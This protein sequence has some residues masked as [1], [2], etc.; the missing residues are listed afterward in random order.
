MR[1]FFL[2]LLL[3]T[4]VIL[5]LPIYGDIVN[6][7]EG[8]KV[9]GEIIQ[10]D[11]N[12]VTLNNFYGTF[13]IKR[14]D[15]LSIIRTPITVS[16]GEMSVT[17]CYTM[18]K[19]RMFLREAAEENINPLPVRSSNKTGAQNWTAGQISFAG[20]YFYLFGNIGESLPY[21]YSG[22]VALDQELGMFIEKRHPLIPATRIEGGYLNFQKGDYR[23]SGYLASVGAIW[24]FSLKR[25]LGG[26]LVFALLPGEAFLD[27]E[28]KESGVVVAS[29][30][31]I[32]QALGGYQR[33]FGSNFSLFVHM[34]YV[35]IYDTDVFFNTLGGSIG[36]SYNAW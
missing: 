1:S 35:Y 19:G 33:S 22:H 25:V 11:T 32:A 15:I 17:M 16:Y 24:N 13:K 31:F 21:G 26:S 5:P 34:R 36:I 12:I 23:I 10:E 30:T 3:M 20:T 9:L 18:D 6:L 14:S 2:L 8:S 7:I 29:N 28:N 27:I 4:G